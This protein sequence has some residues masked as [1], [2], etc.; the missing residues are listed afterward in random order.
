M[1]DLELTKR[2]AEAMGFTV[3]P[4]TAKSVACYPIDDCAIVASNEHGGD[5]IYDP[6]THE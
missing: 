4:F 1:T 5:S 6:L 2:C 3:R